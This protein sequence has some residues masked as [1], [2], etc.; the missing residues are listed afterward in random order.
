MKANAI[1]YKKTSFSTQRS[2]KKEPTLTSQIKILRPVKKKK[3]RGAVSAER[4]IRKLTWIFQIIRKHKWPKGR[5]NSASVERIKT[6]RK[7]DRE[8]GASEQMAQAR[9][10]GTGRDATGLTGRGSPFFG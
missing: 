1:V 6:R 9:G 3:Q 4:N 2:G 10:K 8:G 5:K 7:W